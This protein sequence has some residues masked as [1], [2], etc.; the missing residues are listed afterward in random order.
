MDYA[1]GY[2]TDKK[3]QEQDVGNIDR[4]DTYLQKASSAIK[5]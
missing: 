2:K 4:S 5:A 1:S 3:V